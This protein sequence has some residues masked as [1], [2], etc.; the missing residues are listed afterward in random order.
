M[1]GRSANDPPSRRCPPLRVVPVRADVLPLAPARHRPAPSVP[2][3]CGL[4][5]AR[6]P[7]PARAIWVD[8]ART[9]RPRD[10]ST[11][12]LPAPAAGEH[13]L[14]RRVARWHAG[15]AGAHKSP[16]HGRAAVNL[17]GGVD[18]QVP[19]REIA[20]PRAV[21]D[22]ALIPPARLALKLLLPWPPAPASPPSW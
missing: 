8:A 13:R 11:R 19:G 10:A 18:R 14:P 1:P 21:P 5:S 12:S 4:R 20:P 6:I 16:V 15:G 3:N 17:E 22:C 7:V 9:T 2:G